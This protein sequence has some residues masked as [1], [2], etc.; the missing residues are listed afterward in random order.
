MKQLGDLEKELEEAA[1]ITDT[2]R[3]TRIVRLLLHR[4]QRY[5]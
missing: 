3:R 1:V 5:P 4:I 2:K